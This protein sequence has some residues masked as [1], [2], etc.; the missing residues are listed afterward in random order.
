MVHR[1]AIASFALLVLAGCRRP[2]PVP[3]GGCRYAVRRATCTFDRV[4]GWSAEGR[5]ATVT[6]RTDV[7]EATCASWLNVDVAHYADFVA[8][9]Q[10]LGTVP[11]EIEVEQGGSCPPIGSCRIHV[12]RPANTTWAGNA[13]FDPP[14]P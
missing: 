8:R 6:F 3:E 7:P 14:A 2:A 1:L 9:A 4:D 11:C 5:R 12:P 10:S 13:T